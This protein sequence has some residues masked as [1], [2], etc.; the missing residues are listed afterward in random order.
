MN[1]HCNDNS[2]VEV[3][4][5]GDVN[6]ETDSDIVDIVDGGTG[7]CQP[8]TSTTSTTTTTTTTTTSTTTTTIDPS[9]ECVTDSD[10]SDSRTY[11]ECQDGDPYRITKTYECEEHDCDL[12]TEETRVETCNANEEC[13]DGERNCQKATT[14]TT[15]PTT[16][17]TQPIQCYNSVDCPPT[18]KGTPYCHENNVVQKVTWNTCEKPATPQ[19]K[20][21][22]HEEI[23][24]VQICTSQQTCKDGECEKTT[25]TTQK[26]TTT[27][28]TLI[29]TSTTI[30]PTTTTLP[31]NE[32]T[33]IIQ[34][35]LGYINKLFNTI[36]YLKVG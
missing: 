12:K 23:N 32:E 18:I 2:I 26:T 7:N 20:C 16:T 11:Y 6:E 9:W 1:Y 30:P 27:S 4:V 25:I 24:T 31:Q 29:T 36:R 28:L 15:I 5:S 22:E 17:I 34:K 19:S 13:V 3:T 35:I 8:T 10:C 33:G 21:A 14:T